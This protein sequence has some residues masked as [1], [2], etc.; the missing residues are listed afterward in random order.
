MNIL[1]ISNE[2]LQVQVMPQRGGLLS[3]IKW[4]GH[5]IL[6]LTDEF[7]EDSS[8]WPAGG[9]P[10]LFPVAGRSFIKTKPGRYEAFGKEWPMPIHGFAYGM[11]WNCKEKNDQSLELELLSNESTESIYPWRF[12]L[13]YRISIGENFLNLNASVTNLGCLEQEGY[14]M[15][16]APGFHP[17]LDTREDRGLNHK[18]LKIRFKPKSMIRVSATGSVD[19]ETDFP[20]ADFYTPEFQPLHNGIFP[21]GDSTFCHLESTLMSLTIKSLTSENFVFWT[22]DV[23]QFH[24]IEPWTGVPDALGFANLSSHHEGNQHPLAARLVEDLETFNFSM[25]FQFS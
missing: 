6:R 15:P 10:L 11:Q 25:S 5:E 8:G 3:S 4:K 12:R 7:V 20:L 19:K 9:I 24:C 16:V 23:S 14:P 1:Q 2:N 17:Y 13:V 21:M 22:P 18:A